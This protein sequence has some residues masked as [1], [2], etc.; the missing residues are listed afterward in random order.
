MSESKPVFNAENDLLF[1]KYP[2][3]ILATKAVDKPVETI[4]SRLLDVISGFKSTVGNEILF[5][6]LQR[7]VHRAQLSTVWWP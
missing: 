3:P 1:R 5:E 2:R 6:V 7:I 4:K